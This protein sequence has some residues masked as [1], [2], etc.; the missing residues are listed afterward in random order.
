MRETIHLFKFLFPDNELH[1]EL[2]EKRILQTKS[3]AF[4]GLSAYLNKSN[5]SYESNFINISIKSGENS[6]AIDGRK[7]FQ[8]FHLKLK[9]F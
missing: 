5:K 3:N 6:P 8:P 4:K 1:E 2:I 9:F 7:F